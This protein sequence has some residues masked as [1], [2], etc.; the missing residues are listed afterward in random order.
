MEFVGPGL[1]YHVNHSARL[2]P[3]LSID[4]AGLHTEFL[5]GIGVGC[6]HGDARP[7]VIVIPAI[8]FVVGL[9]TPGAGYRVNLDGRVNG[10]VLHTPSPAILYARLQSHELLRIPAIQ[11]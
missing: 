9:V 7:V 11:R 10:P 3:I 2:L 6:G 4:I 8:Q 5:D 1:H